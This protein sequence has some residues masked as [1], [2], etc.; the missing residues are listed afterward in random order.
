MRRSLPLL[1]LWLA[2]A[3]SLAA[4]SLS[5][6]DGLRAFRI[7]TLVVAGLQPAPGR[8]LAVT[9][10][11]YNGRTAALFRGEG[12]P[13]ERGLRCWFYLDGE[14]QG[15]D[16]RFFSS[17]AVPELL[18]FPVEARPRIAVYGLPP[19]AVGSG[20]S[21]YSPAAAPAELDPGDICV[22][23]VGKEDPEPLQAAG[24]HVLLL[25][26]VSRRPPAE[27]PPSVWRGY[28]LRASEAGAA[29]VLL[30][31]EKERLVEFKERYLRLVT[32]AR[33]HG[34]GQA[35][36]APGARPGRPVL[37]F[38][39]ARP[40]DVASALQR[41]ELAERIGAPL[42]YALLAFYAPILAAAAAHRRLRAALILAGLLLA[43][44]IVFTA[45]SPARVRSL[46]VEFLLPETNERPPDIR[47]QEVTS[48]PGTRRLYRQE[49]G[50]VKSRRLVYQSLLAPGGELPIQ[51][52]SRERIV[53]FNQVPE[54]RQE[55]GR[56]LV[57][58]RNPLAAWSLH[59]P[60]Y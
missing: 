38:P 52:F 40:A 26:A 5:F 35:P 58:F 13:E 6:P 11:L 31:R 57:R 32:E 16:V 41:D 45:L 18:S 55:Q 54:V 42:G 36:G 22:L 53:R 21:W 27:G 39:G 3:G 60:R 29:G 49:G 34:A 59:D 10:H 17:G 2:A 4:Q 51:M 37:D 9:G 1:L 14:I 28:L 50:P 56:L 43:G 20:G 30:E 7:N 25:G 46:T 19:A 23:E 24:I 12:I 33:F 15:L 8:R 48:G 44:F 47:L